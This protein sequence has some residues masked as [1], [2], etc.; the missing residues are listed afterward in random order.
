[1]YNE[2]LL[3]SLV[4]DEMKRMLSYLL[5]KV[6]KFVKIYK[7]NNLYFDF[8]YNYKL[9]LYVFRMWSELKNGLDKFICKKKK[10][11]NLC[12]LFFFYCIIVCYCVWIIKED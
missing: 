10:K 4:F 2:K 9:F 3:G 1:M 6:N 5:L 8:M 7:L 11:L 12:Y